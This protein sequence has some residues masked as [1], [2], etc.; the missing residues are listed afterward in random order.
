MPDPLALF[1]GWFEAA[2]ASGLELPEAMTLATADPEARPS[3]RTVLLKGVDER[4]FTFFTNYESRKGRQLAANPNAA[5][6]FHWDLEPRRQVL[7]TGTVERVSPEESD[8]YFATRPPG[9]RLA[10]WASRQSTPIAG[11]EEL[12]RAYAEAERAY[13]DDPPR[14]EHWGGFV[15]APETIE[16]WE[17]RPNRLHERIR[18]SRTPDGGWREE[19]LAP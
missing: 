10:A 18:Y 17:S 15:L 13:G 6:V 11:R 12:E 16:F 5:L 14:P 1:R 7:V 9:S 8:A 2:R 3:A 4:G 19:H